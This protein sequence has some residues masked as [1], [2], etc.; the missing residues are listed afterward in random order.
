MHRKRTTAPDEISGP[1]GSPDPRTRTNRVAASVRALPPRATAR[2]VVELA[3]HRRRLRHRPTLS[4]LQT[5][6][7]FDG[8]EPCTYRLDR[9]VNW[10]PESLPIGFPHGADGLCFAHRDGEV[11]VLPDGCGFSLT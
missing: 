7:H 8:R 4:Q 6:V 10:L 3:R 2:A 9:D 1:M 11:V 5:M